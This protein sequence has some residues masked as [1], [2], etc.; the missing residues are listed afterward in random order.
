MR[1]IRIDETINRGWF[2]IHGGLVAQTVS[3]RKAQSNRL[4][5]NVY[6]SRVF[7]DNEFGFDEIRGFQ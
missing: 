5:Y 3:L 6:L 7:C 4:C 2:I 1:L